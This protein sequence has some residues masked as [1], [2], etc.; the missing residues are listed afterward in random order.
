MIDN[1]IFCGPHKLSQEAPVQVLKQSHTN[2]QPGGAASV[3]VMCAAL[4]AKVSLFGRIWRPDDAPEETHALMDELECSNV[5]TRGVFHDGSMGVTPTKTRIWAILDR[6]HQQMLR[7]DNECV[8]P[9]RLTTNE[10]R[11][12]AERCV[13]FEDA[14]VIIISDYNK[15]FCTQALFK[16]LPRQTGTLGIRYVDPP[17]DP[18]WM[19]TYR[20][21]GEY[22]PYFVTNRKKSLGMTAADLAHA[23]NACVVTTQG[24]GGCDYATPA[25]SSPMLLTV[26]RYPVDVTGCGDQFMAVFAMTQYANGS[27]AACALANVAAGLQAMCVG[28]IPVTIHG[29]THE[30]FPG[31][32]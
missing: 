13:V 11:V 2:I 20:G 26:P 4:G 23:M 28:C 10:L 22:F 25:T 24:S 12:K 1:H 8:R 7:I 18:H 6:Y 16:A 9:M 14:H 19:N 29:L 30:L 21:Q 17:D 32:K 27:L 3:A 31:E 5:D 15:G